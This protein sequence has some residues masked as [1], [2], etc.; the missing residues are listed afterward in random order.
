MRPIRF[1]MLTR[2]IPRTG[3][4]LPVLG[5]GTFRAFDTSLTAAPIRESLGEV[6][7]RMI[8][9][10]GTMIDSSPMYGR[11]EAVVGELLDAQTAHGKVFLATKVWTRG[12]R[13]GITAM[14]ESLRLLRAQSIA[15]MQVHNLVDTDTHL[16]TLRDWKADGRIRYIGITHYTASAFDALKKTIAAHPDID[17]CQFP[18]SVIEL[19]AE[20]DLLSFCADHG[21]ATLI[22]RPFGQDALFAKVDDRPLPA[23]AGEI[24]CT[25]WAQVALKYLIADPRVT[26]IIPATSKPHHM[27]DNLKAVSGALP[28]PAL[29]KRMAAFFADL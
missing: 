29:R 6:I 4:A 22:N 15:L 16:A 19:A 21:V 17:F 10:G 2:P 14:D 11:A 20:K 18:Y 3:E 7:Q 26:C 27:I 12:K 24:D 1:V 8:D 25:S 13:D 9:A 23:W 5:L 28:D